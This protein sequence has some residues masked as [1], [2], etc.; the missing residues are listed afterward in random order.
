M[1]TGIK[2][3]TLL[4]LLASLISGCSQ[5]LAASSNKES[6]TSMESSG[7]SFS[8][9]NNSSSASSNERSSSSTSSVSYSSVEL[10][11]NECQNH[12]LNETVVKEATL[13]EKG[14]KHYQCP[15]CGASFDEDYYKMDECA[16]NDITYMDDEEEHAILIEGVLPYGVSVQYEN[17]TIKGL[18]S[19]EATA[20]FINDK[21]QVFLEK[22]ANISIIANTGI[23]N[24][25]ITTVDGEDP[26]WHSHNGIKEYKQITA[27]AIDNCP[28]A[29][30]KS[31]VTGEMKVRGNSTNQ[32][33]VTKRAFRLKLDGKP[34]LLGLNGGAKCKSWVLLADFFDQSMFRN[35]IAFSIGNDL[36]NHS[37]Y[38]ASDY[39]HVNLYMN[40]DYRG[41]Y[42]L[43]EQQQANKNRIPVNEPDEDVTSTKV[44]YIVEIDGLVNSSKVDST[45]HIGACHIFI[46]FIDRD[47]V[48]VS[49]LLFG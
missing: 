27:F 34:N 3:L 48:F 14:V 28:D 49:L 12:Q 11:P 15:N 24:I 25:K 40:G 47:T 5:P 45:T 10:N 2:N 31:G 43:A 26:D 1:K 46:W 19:K 38:Y 13:L 35:A 37:G 39:R 9:E 22:K 29:Y 4:A 23:P 33:Q 44:G 20:K 8:S 21:N 6:I 36:F 42:L 30:K 16:F 17:N 18:G 7:S 41:V 32:E